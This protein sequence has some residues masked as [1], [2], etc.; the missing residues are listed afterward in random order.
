MPRVKKQVRLSRLFT[1]VNCSFLCNCVTDDWIDSATLCVGM[2][3]E[4]EKDHGMRMRIFA[5]SR[6]SMRVKIN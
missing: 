4:K 1:S 3:R 5:I 2:T 6:L